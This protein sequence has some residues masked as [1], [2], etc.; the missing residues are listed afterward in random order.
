M[1]AGG[2]CIFSAASGRIAHQLGRIAHLL[3]ITSSAR[4][5]KRET[6]I[7]INIYES[8]SLKDVF[9]DSCFKH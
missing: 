3:Y 5:K 8:F 4:I 7:N 1:G 2:R 6:L 9:Q